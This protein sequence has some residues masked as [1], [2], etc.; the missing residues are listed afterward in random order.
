MPAFKMYFNPWLN[1]VDFISANFSWITAI[2]IYIV[3]VLTAMQVGLPTNALQNDK[4]FH[5]ASYAFT[6][7]VILGPRSYRRYLLRNADILV[8][9]IPNWANAKLACYEIKLTTSATPVLSA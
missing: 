2:I 4:A 3:V 8:A 5:A 7:L 6:V 1:Y 9:L